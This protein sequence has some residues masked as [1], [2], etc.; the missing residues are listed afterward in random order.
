MSLSNKKL[1]SK[2]KAKQT[3]LKR[4]IAWWPK[5]QPLLS[6]RIMPRGAP[7]VSRE[8]NSLHPISE[9]LHTYWP[10]MK[11]GRKVCFGY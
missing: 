6:Q 4:R 7:L 10:L 3:L 1:A 11:K 8:K 5:G 2:L 9:K